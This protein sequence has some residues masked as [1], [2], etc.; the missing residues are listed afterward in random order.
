MKRRADE[1]GFIATTT[2]ILQV[3]VTESGGG[4]WREHRKSK[5]AAT[6]QIENQPDD[7]CVVCPVA[8]PAPPSQGQFLIWPMWG[9][10]LGGAGGVGGGRGGHRHLSCFFVLADTSTSTPPPPP[11]DPSAHQG[12][13][14]TNR[15]GPPL[16]PE[17]QTEARSS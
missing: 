5:I 9:G 17:S 3:F 12:V 15:R 11:P 8:P 10:R 1:S 14:P 7:G 16:D 2:E 6:S 13:R 4:V